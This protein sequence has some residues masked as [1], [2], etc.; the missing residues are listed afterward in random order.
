MGFTCRQC[1]ALL[2]GYIQREL[3]PRQ[4]SFVSRHLNSCAECYVVYTTQQQ[5]E[6]EL[7]FAV[8]RIGG[9]AP[10]RLD[11]MRAAIMVEMAR[12]AAKPKTP[13]Q[14]VQMRYS[15]SFAA[16]ILMIALL[17]PWSIQSHAFVP[18]QPLPVNVTPQGTSVVA[19]PA[20]EAVTLTATMQANY[21]P[22]PDGTETP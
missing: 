16:I 18:T 15:L 6:R 7:A 14:L 3:S 19:L 17:V 12:P 8:P 2:P 9:G 11:K 13:P 20:T 5:L 21:A 22:L 1:R 10:P 4:R